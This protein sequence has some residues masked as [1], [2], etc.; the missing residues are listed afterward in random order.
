MHKVILGAL[1]LTF[2][3]S[4]VAY[5]QVDNT[6]AHSPA[7]P[8]P[9]EKMA[10]PPPPPPGPG[11]MN[12]TEMG[13][14]GHKRHGEWRHHKGMWMMSKAAHFRVRSGDMMVDVKC[15]DD[16]TTKECGDVVMQ[17]VNKLSAAQG[18]DNDYGTDDNGSNDDSGNS[19]GAE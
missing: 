12:G 15:A 16:D 9:G 7:A 2:A 11:A 13:G 19:G 8:A 5:A 1:A 14:P 10:P 4:A 3:A 18:D 17:I 6:P